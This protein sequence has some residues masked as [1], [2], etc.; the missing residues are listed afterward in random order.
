MP[1][2]VEYSPLVSVIIPIFNAEKF[3]VPAVES[4]LNQTYQNLE[5]IIVDDASTDGTVEKLSSFKDDRIKLLTNQNN[6]GNYASR[7][8]GIRNAKG[9]YIAVMDSDDIASLDRIAKQVDF[10]EN[11]YT[12]SFIGSWANRID[13][14]D[15]FIEKIQTETNV[16]KIKVNSLFQVEFIHPTMMFRLEIFKLHYYYDENYLFAGD[17]ELVTRLINKFK[18][19]VIN[20]YL[21]NYRR[22]K[23]QISKKN[24]AQQ[25][26][27][28]LDVV[29]ARFESYGIKISSDRRFLIKLV[30]RNHDNIS[31]S[32]KDLTLLI[33]LFQDLLAFN[34][35][36]NHF[37]MD[38][39]KNFLRQ[40]YLDCF[41]NYVG[42]F[43]DYARIYIYTEFKIF[44]SVNLLGLIKLIKRGLHSLKE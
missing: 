8:L 33:D 14:N 26:E 2:S 35:K 5:V 1:L 38:K 41:Y 6:L 12:I 10:L 4:I 37:D 21:I 13:E 22:S 17:Y 39:L 32:L 28:F 40:I 23:D 20:E 30:T 16:E 24:I 9:K 31:I 3:V 19:H 34:H 29:Q 43:Y 25:T 27:Y 11:N 18:F 36:Q 42:S 15:N 44:R 7:N